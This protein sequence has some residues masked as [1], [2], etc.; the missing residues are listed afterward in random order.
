MKRRRRTPSEAGFK[1]QPIS[2]ADL[3]PGQLS[4][5]SGSLIC[6]CLVQ[7]F[8]PPQPEESAHVRVHERVR[9]SFG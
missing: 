9:G 1:G 5:C 8:V 3:T 2:P 6:G 7:A 4:A